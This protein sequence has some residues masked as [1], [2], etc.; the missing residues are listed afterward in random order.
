MAAAPERTVS[1]QQETRSSHCITGGGSGAV[2]V[3]VGGVLSWA[4]TFLEL[5]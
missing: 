3:I 4:D 5:C 2:G 1:E